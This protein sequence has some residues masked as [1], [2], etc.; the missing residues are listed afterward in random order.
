MERL[1]LESR[2]AHLKEWNMKSVLVLRDGLVVSEWHDRGKDSI[3]PLFSC[4]KSV[5]SALIGIALDRGDLTS[6]E[7]PV[8][9]FLTPPEGSGAALAKLNIGHLLTMTAGF[10]WPDFD[11]PY[12]AFRA[13]GDPVKFVFDQPIISEPGTAFA[14]N[15]GGSHLLSA[16]LTEATGM[17]ALR[18]AEE[19]LFGPLGFRAARWMERGGVNEGGTGL[20]LYGRDL[21]KFGQLYAQ[22]GIF[23]GRR[24]LSAEWTRQST[25][26]HHRG[27]L[28][29]EPPIYGGYGYHWWHSPQEHNGHADCYFAF[30]HGGQYLL[31]LPGDGLVIVIRKQVTKRN[32]AILSRRLIFEHIVPALRAHR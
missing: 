7:Q 30:G 28:Q 29:Y 3:G 10:D 17:S 13:S 32:D 18:Y 27:L 23:D 26:L 11:K 15:S 25:K 16:I 19:R 1:D 5:L 2:S 12:K 6:L 14:Y 22:E 24:L 31:V 8:T 21:A 9:D 20:H 4:T